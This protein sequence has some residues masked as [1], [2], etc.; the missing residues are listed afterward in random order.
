MVPGYESRS[1]MLAAALALSM[2]AGIAWAL[3]GAVRGYALARAVVD[4]PNHRSSHS[5]P[6]PRGGGLAI[7]SVALLGIPAVTLL[8]ELPR[9]VAIALSGGGLLIA[10]IGWIDDHRHVPAAARFVVHLA[11]ASWAVGWLG[12]MP[13]LY[14]GK[15]SVALGL[16]GVPVA[17]VGVIW[18]TNLYNFMDG[19]D[20]LAGGEAV[21]IGLAGGGLL[22]V[23][24]Q[25]SL[26]L[27]SFL[28]AASSA[29]FLLWNWAPAKI[30]MGDVGSG[31][32]GF[33]FGA[34]A[35]ASAA[36]Q[37]V[38]VLVWILLLGVF[39][40]DATATLLRRLARGER[41]YEAHRSHAY[42]RAVRAGWTH[43]R[44]TG[45]V[46]GLNAVLV[47]LAFLAT[48]RPALLFPAL[49]AGF[50]LLTVVY[51]R[52]ERIVPM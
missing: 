34:L 49:A 39:A 11:A 16:L 8:G 21:S 51:L 25:R 13:T 32:L 5:V 43:A 23:E 19:I 36:V 3:T 7:A 37:A 28:L 42:Q 31:L 45:G 12:G 48:G 27:V 1:M 44:V 6:T 22:L 29:G 10:S 4:V 40:Y 52:I 18:F 35:V 38:P 2:G 14:L 15:T 50:I 33:L 26:A 20:G 47:G 24:G 41:W 46:L 17:I 30:F 9:E